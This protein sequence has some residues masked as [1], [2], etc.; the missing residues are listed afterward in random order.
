[1]F[2]DPLCSGTLMNLGALYFQ[3]ASCNLGFLSCVY[4]VL[5]NGKIPLCLPSVHSTLGIGAVSEDL[6]KGCKLINDS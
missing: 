3:A 5:I 4:G 1:M 6:W 2:T